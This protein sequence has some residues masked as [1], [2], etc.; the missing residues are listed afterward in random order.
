M[1]PRIGLVCVVCGLALLACVS[2][3]W[4]ADAAPAWAVQPAAAAV[5][6]A[7]VDA[8]L[9]AAADKAPAATRSFKRAL[10]QAAVDSYK[11]KQISRWDL[12]RIRMALTFRPAAMA[13]AQ[14]C[15]I[16]QACSDGLMRAPADGLADAFDWNAI[17]EF[18]RQLL[19][20]ILEIIKI[21]SV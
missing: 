16:D 13:E 11:A 12:A 3:G 10:E 9:A 7:T 8:Q 5:Q 14:A 17:L 4:C 19:P 15:V 2:V 18:I 6:V 20:L 21:F 1:R